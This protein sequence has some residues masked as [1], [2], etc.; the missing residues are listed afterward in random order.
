MRDNTVR[1]TLEGGGTAVGSM[2]F[3][4]DA[5]GI[6]RIAAAAGADFLIYDMEHTGWSLET[7]GRL[8]SAAGEGLVPMVR[9][10]RP[11]AGSSRA[12]STWAPSG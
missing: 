1:T 8:V 12:S 3:E 6:S 4:F 9:V 5:R 10:P 11:S 7:I 2:V